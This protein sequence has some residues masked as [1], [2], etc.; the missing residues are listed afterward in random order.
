MDGSKN[1]K[2]FLQFCKRENQVKEY[3]TDPGSTEGC[4]WEMVAQE[5]ESG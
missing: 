1:K 4:V 3:K 5:K 2:G